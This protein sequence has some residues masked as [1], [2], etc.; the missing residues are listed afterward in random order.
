MRARVTKTAGAG[1]TSPM[2]VMDMNV[3]NF[4]AG[5]Q[6]IVSGTVNYTVQYTMDQVQVAGYVQSTGNWFNYDYAELINATT[7]QT[8]NFIVPVS[9]IQIVQNSGSGSVTTTLWQV[10]LQ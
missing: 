6:C 7:N 2:L 5:I 1:T 3:N 9:A 10:G 4:L 8:G